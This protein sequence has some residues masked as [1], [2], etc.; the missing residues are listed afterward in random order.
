MHEPIVFQGSDDHYRDGRATAIQCHL[1]HD[2]LLCCVSYGTAACCVMAS[3]AR[4]L[5]VLLF[6]SIWTAEDFEEKRS[7]W[8]IYK[9]LTTVS[10]PNAMF[11]HF[12][13][14]FDHPHGGLLSLRG[15]VEYASHLMRRLGMH[16]CLCD[17]VRSLLI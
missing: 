4:R 13:A 17:F 6:C 15:A 14:G 5:V 1:R 2:E 10:R 12:K 7:G 16:L 8:G 9:R 11:S 3:T